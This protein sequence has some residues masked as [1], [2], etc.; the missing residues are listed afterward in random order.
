MTTATIMTMSPAPTPTP[1]DSSCRRFGD[2][3]VH[4]RASVPSTYACSLV[5]VG[6]HPSANSRPLETTQGSRCTSANPAE[7]GPVENASG[8][9]RALRKP[10]PEAE[11]A[12]AHLTA[13]EPAHQ[14]SI[15]PVRRCRPRPDG[16]APPTR[17][18]RPDRRGVRTATADRLRQNVGQ[19]P[20]PM[21]LQVARCRLQ[22]GKS[23]AAA[24]MSLD[25]AGSG[26]TARRVPRPMPVGGRTRTRCQDE[27]SFLR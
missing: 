20:R 17:S 3:M 27:V 19:G 22:R 7:S 26:A 21:R 16:S 9:R 2:T 25:R 23:L 15:L 5:T 6:F 11:Y 10:A 12:V 1:S 13:L 8:Q 4:H 24:P 18:Q 14:E